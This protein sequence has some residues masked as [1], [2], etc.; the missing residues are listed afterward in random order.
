[1]PGFSV[2]LDAIVKELFKVC[3]IEDAICC[4][5]R[6]VDNEFVLG[7][8]VL[9]GRGLRLGMI[10]KWRGVSLLRRALS[11][12]TLGTDHGWRLEGLFER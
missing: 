1:M 12:A 7:D 5:L 3:A 6:V 8:G 4:R 9:A 10:G 2:Y 11:K